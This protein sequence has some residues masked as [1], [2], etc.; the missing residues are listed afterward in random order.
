MGPSLR[1]HR[2]RKDLDGSL[3]S[4]PF[5]FIQV[6]SVNRGDRLCMNEHYKSYKI[7]FALRDICFVRWLLVA[8]SSIWSFDP[9]RCSD[10]RRS[11]EKSLRLSSKSEA[12]AAIRYELSCWLLLTQCAEDDF[13]ERSKAIMRPC[14]PGCH[15]GEAAERV[16]RP[17]SSIRKLTGRRALQRNHRR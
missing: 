6:T 2:R 1:L 16:D 13:L 15:A 9:S 3:N 8:F 4:L 7:E 10:L 12:A 5:Q 11:M 17:C 14:R